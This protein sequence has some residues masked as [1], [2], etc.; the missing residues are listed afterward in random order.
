MGMGMVASVEKKILQMPVGA[1]LAGQPDRETAG[2]SGLLLL[3]YV[4][5]V[6]ARDRHELN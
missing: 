2:S 4:P 5:Y 3:L 1:A 6:N